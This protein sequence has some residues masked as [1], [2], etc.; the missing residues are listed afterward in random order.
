MPFTEM[1]VTVAAFSALALAFVSILRL[2]GIGIAHRTIRKAVDKDPDA[3]Q[4]L[5]AQIASPNRGED[6]ERL[7]VILVA[8]GVAIVVASLVI[9]DPAWMHYAIA[10]ALFPLI[11]GTALWL[12]QFMLGRARRRGQGQ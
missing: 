4:T 1:V 8:V 7:S 9:G 3:A 11:V 6:D 12:R 5:L 10:G 2:I